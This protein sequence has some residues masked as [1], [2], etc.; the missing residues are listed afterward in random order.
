MKST[1]YFKLFC[2][3]LLVLLFSGCATKAPYDYTA[4]KESHPTSILVLPPVNNTPEVAASYSVLSYATRPLAEAGYYVMP[5][6]LVAEAFKENG[7]TQPSDMHATSTEK[8][9]KIFGADAALYITISKYGTTYQV[10]DSQ[11]LV[12]AQANLV[13]LKTGKTL[14]T[15]SA[16]AS[17]AESNNQN[18]GGLAVLLITAII[19]QV[20]AST[21]DQSH[22][23]AGV[24]TARLLSAGQKNGLLYGPRSPHYGKDRLE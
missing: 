2:A 18:Q 19:K 16:Q 17:S 3:A 12:A 20:V 23:I 6:T 8:L 9:S 10:I 24:A 21:T 22:Q 15:G 7:M 11:S 5:V 4:F 13:D 14:W 1:S